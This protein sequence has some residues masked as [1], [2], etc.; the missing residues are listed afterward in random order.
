M[1]HTDKHSQRENFNWLEVLKRSCQHHSFE[2][3]THHR[4]TFSN[5]VK[6]TLSVDAVN[7]WRLFGFG[8][9]WWCH[10]LF[11]GWLVF[12]VFWWFLSLGFLLLLDCFGC[13]WF[14]FFKHNLW[15]HPH[16]STGFSVPGCLLRVPHV[17]SLQ[18]ILEPEKQALT[19]G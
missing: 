8:R 19:S 9:K 10:F 12:L 4:F 13:F 18:F 3:N 15:K 6:K 16:R 14:F 11:V 7:D 5:T 17:I 2:H 1:L